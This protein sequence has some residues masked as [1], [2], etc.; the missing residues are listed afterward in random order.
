MEDGIL[1]LGKLPD[2]S[3][4]LFIRPLLLKYSLAGETEHSGGKQWG[5]NE[6]Q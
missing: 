6:E 5:K 1:P 3:S 4:A 2:V